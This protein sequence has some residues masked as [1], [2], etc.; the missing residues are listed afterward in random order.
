MSGICNIYF[1]YLHVASTADISK[2]NTGFRCVDD[3]C[4]S[5][6]LEKIWE[7]AM[8]DID[9]IILPELFIEHCHESSVWRYG[10]GFKV[11]DL[12]GNSVF[13]TVCL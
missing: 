3:Y 5:V 8:P 13:W 4:A 1:G 12:D 9:D 6:T 10:D 7:N 11:A 2:I